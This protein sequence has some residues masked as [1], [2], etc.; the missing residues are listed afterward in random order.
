MVSKG[1]ECYMLSKIQNEI[2][3]SAMGT[4]SIV[5]IELW[6]HC[7][8]NFCKH[9]ITSLRQWLNCMLIFS[10][11]IAMQRNA[12]YK[13][14][15]LLY[16]F[17]SIRVFNPIY[18]F[19]SSRIKVETFRNRLLFVTRTRNIFPWMEM[20]IRQISIEWRKNG[21]KKTPNQSMILL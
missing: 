9:C 12:Q 1:E 4:K 17:F 7:K 16:I 18:E 20:E 2:E 21:E 19:V 11:T 3:A 8:T 13:S 5:W 6:F 10:H 15:L 14:I